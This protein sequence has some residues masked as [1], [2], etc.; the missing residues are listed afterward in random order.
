MRSEYCSLDAGSEPPPIAPSPPDPAVLARSY[1]RCWVNRR[2]PLQAASEAILKP[3]LRKYRALLPLELWRAVCIQAMHST[4]AIVESMQAA[5]QPSTP[6][7]QSVSGAKH[8][9][10]TDSEASDGV[11]HGEHAPSLVEMRWED[12]NAAALVTAQLLQRALFDVL[13]ESPSAVRHSNSFCKSSTAALLKLLSSSHCA[14]VCPEF[15]V[16][17]RRVDEVGEEYCPGRG[18]H[19]HLAALVAAGR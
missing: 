12:L 16:K 14:S 5:P 11:M 3:L 7:E 1:A 6:T 19:A 15:A 9:S 18:S 13:Q 17:T 2:V 4:Q 10:S 8:A